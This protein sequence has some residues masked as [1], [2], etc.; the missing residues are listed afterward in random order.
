[1]TKDQLKKLNE[2]TNR[3]NFRAKVKGLLADVKS[4]GEHPKM[5]ETTR[6][7]ALQAKYFRE[8]K[9]KT[10]NSNHFPGPDGMAKAVD[11]ADGSKEQAWN[12]ATKRFWLLIGSS[13]M[14][15]GL[16]WG[17]L[18]G[19]SIAQ[20]RVIMKALLQLR[21]AGWPVAHPAYGVDIGWDPAHVENGSNWPTL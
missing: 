15:R 8:G 1:M 13:C 19:K 7:R 14:A 3:N 4:K 18:F 11:I 21:A 17:G 10:M 5:F 2:L 12:H 16:G 20:R 6:T 9:S